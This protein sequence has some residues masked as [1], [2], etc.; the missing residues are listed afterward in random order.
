VVGDAGG[1]VSRRS[2][3]HTAASSRR[4]LETTADTQAVEFF[5]SMTQ[6]FSVVLLTRRSVIDPITQGKPEF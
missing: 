3:R 6:V 2:R 5:S 4:R 1:Q